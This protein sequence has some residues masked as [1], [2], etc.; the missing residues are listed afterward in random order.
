MSARIVLSRKGFDSTTGVIHSPVIDEIFYSLPIPEGGSDLFYKD[1]KAKGIALDL[2]TII[3]QLGA[4]QYSECHVDPNLNPKLYGLDTEDGWSPAF[5]Q[6]E[7]ALSHLLETNGIKSGDVFLFFGRF[8]HAKF[9]MNRIEYSKSKEFH[10]IFGFME[11]GEIVNI[12][13][14]LTAEMKEKYF[15]HPHV[16]H[17]EY[18]HN[19]STLFIPANKSKHGFAKTVGTFKFSKD[20]VLTS[21]DGKLSDW[22]MPKPFWGKNFTYKLNID[23]KGKVKSPGRG[24]EMVGNANTEMLGW[25]KDKIKNH[26]FEL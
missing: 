7:A 25:I 6:D 1:L 11:I 2:L 15:N 14:G 22:Q 4:K 9:N 3:R 24:Q 5:G 19:N 12:K 23:K 20:L 13:M 26:L 17:Q 10:A 8:K 16:K 21:D 18:Y